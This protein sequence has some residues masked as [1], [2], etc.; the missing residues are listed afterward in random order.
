MYVKEEAKHIN[1]DIGTSGVKRRFSNIAP[2][3]VD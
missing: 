3:S 1:I 2:H